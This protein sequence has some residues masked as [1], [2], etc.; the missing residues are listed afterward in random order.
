MVLESY[1]IIWTLALMV[2]GASALVG[3]VAILPW[4]AAALA[5]AGIAN[6]LG[7]GT[8]AQLFWF[9]FILI[10][11]VFASRKIFR[12][13]LNQVAGVIT[14]T[15]DE[16][17]GTLITVDIV[18]KITP[19]RGEGRTQSGKVWNVEH[20]TGAILRKNQVYVCEAVE[21]I[22]LKIA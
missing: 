15:T 16:L 1:W 12:Q 18:M 22:R 5:A 17:I 4:L 9:S 3:E 14:E 21:G 10:V 8:D 6:F 7:A 11:T 19:S 13:S 2:L 20:C